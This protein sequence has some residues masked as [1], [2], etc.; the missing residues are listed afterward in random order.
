MS[1]ID[2]F[3]PVKLQWAALFSASCILLTG[4]GDPGPQLGELGAVKGFRGVVAVEEPRAALAAFD[5]LS[6]GGTA[7]D[8]AAAAFFT[9][10][11]TYPVGAGLGG[12]GICIAYDAISDKV[13]SIDFL[14][15]AAANGG[16]MMVP[17]AL[18]GVA[19]LH[20]RYGRR[21]G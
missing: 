16:T 15:R 10:T 11:V 2:N 3:R 20:A 4:C 19:S 14:P 13:E 9:M 21:I 18:R 12:G 5:I 8:A 7:S 6:A 1:L 17:G